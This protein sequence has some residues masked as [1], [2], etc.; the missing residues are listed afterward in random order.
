MLEIIVETVTD[1]KAAEAGGATQL[2]L[3]SDFLE[4][5]LTPS[6]GMVEQIRDQVK[7]DV[8][9]MIRPYANGMVFSPDD[10]KII[11]TDIRLGAE[12]GADGF[13]LGALTQNG[14]IDV[15][16]IQR[17]QDAARG[18]PL[19]FHLAWEMT[20]NPQQALEDLIR[21]GIKSARASGD[22]GI[23]GKVA[24]GLVALKGYHEQAAGRI[25]LLL[26]GG[27]NHENLGQFIQ[28]TGIPN[29][30]AGTSVRSPQT[31][32]GSVSEFKV[33]QLRLALDE[34]LSTLK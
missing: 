30:H 31:P 19:H 6:I 33:R 12:Y 34:A 21:L 10:I 27:V 14:Q 24:N 1:A 20:T 9:M 4:F 5:G 32:K 2:D 7:I 8:L 11:C 15:D 22:K 23:G 28:A 17:F 3:K 18:I 25:D 16:A 13:L 26:A 29:A